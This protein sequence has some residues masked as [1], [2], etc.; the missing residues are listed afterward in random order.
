MNLREWMSANGHTQR[1][2]AKL[3]PVSQQTVAKW[4]DGYEPKPYYLDALHEVTNGQV[5]AVDFF[6]TRLTFSPKERQRRAAIRRLQRLG[7]DGLP[8]IDART[9]AQNR[10]LEYITRPLAKRKKDADSE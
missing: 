8:E 7:V 6:I 10:P 1:S 5:T 4:L 2:L 3:I 9:Q